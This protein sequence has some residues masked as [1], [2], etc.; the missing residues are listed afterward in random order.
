MVKQPNRNTMINVVAKLG[1]MV[2][3]HKKEGTKVK[4]VSRRVRLMNKKEENSEHFS[5]TNCF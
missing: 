5:S 1:E 2:L 4:L 3:Y